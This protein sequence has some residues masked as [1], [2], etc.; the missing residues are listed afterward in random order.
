MNSKI[1]R[2]TAL[3]TVKSFAF[4]DFGIRLSNAQAKEIRESIAD[5]CAL[6]SSER[7][8]ST[9]G[10]DDIHRMSS[11]GVRYYNN[12]TSRKDWNAGYAK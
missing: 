1:N 10:T 7:Y 11:E 12:F 8:T 4:D 3:K 5:G 6:W 9:R 2:R